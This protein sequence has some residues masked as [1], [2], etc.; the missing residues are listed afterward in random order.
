MDACVLLIQPVVETVQQAAVSR[1]RLATHKV[2]T[3][4]ANCVSIA[5]PSPNA[6]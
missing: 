2:L 6:D 4:C 3:S 1:E 5:T